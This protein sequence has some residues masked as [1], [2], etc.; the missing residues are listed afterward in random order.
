MKSLSY[1]ILLKTSVESVAKSGDD[2][3]KASP[4]KQIF[5]KAI[6]IKDSTINRCSGYLPWKIL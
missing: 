5:F 3:H 1:G 4:I 2:N 6:S